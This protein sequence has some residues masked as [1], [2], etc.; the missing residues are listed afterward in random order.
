MAAKKK[1]SIGSYPE[2]S[3]A[4][5]RRRRD[6]ARELI[7]LGKDP[8]AKSNRPNTAPKW[9][10]AIPLPKSAANISTSVFVKAWQGHHDQE[11]IS[12]DLS[13]AG[14]CPYHNWPHR[15]AGRAARV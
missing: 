13:G 15:R 4:D 6:E 12:P 3:L 5:A 7:A 14:A 10:L 1:L 9:L 2:I 11:R 8:R